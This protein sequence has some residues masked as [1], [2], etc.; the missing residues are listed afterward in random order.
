MT[1][2]AV[3][4]AHCRHADHRSA[5]P[6]PAPSGDDLKLLIVLLAEHCEFGAGSMKSLA[7]TVATPSKN[8]GRNLSSSPA[9][10]GPPKTTVVAKPGG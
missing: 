8:F 3:C 9:L 6:G 2:P 5:C 10:A 1:A 4:L 7:T